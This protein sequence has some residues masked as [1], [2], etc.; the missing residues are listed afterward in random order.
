MS[1][2]P[3]SELLKIKHLAAEWM[4][5]RRLGMTEIS[6]W[7]GTASSL[8]QEAIKCALFKNVSA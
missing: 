2:V 1:T 7:W 3:L 4:A 6:V 8:K 5:L